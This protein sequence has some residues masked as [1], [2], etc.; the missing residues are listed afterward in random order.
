MALPTD[1]TAVEIAASVVAVPPLA[2]NADLT[3]DVDANRALCAHLQAGGVTTWLYG[4]NANF[5]NIA[6]SEFESTMQAMLDIA[7]E[8]G[9][10]STLVIPSVGPDYGKLMDQAEICSKLGFRTAMVLPLD[11]PSTAEGLATGVRNFAHAFGKKV[12]LYVKSDAVYTPE[13]IAG[14]VDEGLIVA[15]KYAVVRDDPA[16]DEFLSELCSLIDPRLIISGIGERPAGA[17][18]TEFGVAGFT[19]GSVCIAPRLSTMMLEA[20][21]AGDAAE[22]ARIRELFIPVED[23]RDMWSPIRTMHEAVTLSGIADMGPMLPMLS[24]LEDD[25]HDELRPAARALLAQNTAAQ[26]L[27]DGAGGAAKL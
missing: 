11:F 15:V 3:V 5:Y 23:L 4:G 13:A 9:D 20:L 27:V 26:G 17:H 8:V 21:H 16:E 6:V 25:K 2:R 24:N 7:D 12:I 19:S 14:L 18:F 10:A 1:L 22:A